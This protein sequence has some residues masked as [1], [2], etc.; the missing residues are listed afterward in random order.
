M[1]PRTYSAL[2]VTEALG[3]TAP[4]ILDSMEVVP[5]HCILATALGLRVLQ[6][7]GIPSNAMVVNAQYGNDAWV[8]WGREMQFQG[9][10]RDPNHPY[11][12]AWIVEIDPA[13]PSDPGN[14][15][16]H[17]VIHFFHAGQ[18][19]FLDLTTGQFNRPA[20][21]INVPRASILKA[22]RVRGI[23]GHVSSNAG[24]SC[25]Y[26]ERRG[27]TDYK[28]RSDW[29]KVMKTPEYD[30][31]VFEMTY[32]VAMYL[33]KPTDAEWWPRWAP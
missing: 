26:E 4:M 21:G 33:T 23:L 9:D 27:H 28:D 29:V 32:A 7:I 18:N 30:R 19:Y 12:D 1:E 11:H 2:E 17:L 10:P 20:K 14:W 8:R 5:N 25:F 31:V 6:R 13:Q 22:R 3:R 15:S 16:G 24:Y